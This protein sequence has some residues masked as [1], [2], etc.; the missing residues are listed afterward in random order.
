MTET[1]ASFSRDGRW[2]Y[3]R[4]D[5]PDGRDI[6]RVPSDGGGPP[7]RVTDQGGLL[8]RESADGRTLVY[9]KRDPTSPL[10]GRPVAGGAERQLVDCVQSRSLADGPDGMYYLA[11]A[12]DPTPLYRLDPMTG[13]VR[14]VGEIATG[15][16]AGAY[17][18][19][20]PRDGTVLFSKTTGGADL[21]MIDN[22]R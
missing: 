14:R 1:L 9:T 13:A 22:F 6:W 10:Y 8:A 19:V 5:R 15:A 11:C 12:D 3:Y 16:P 7:E 18:A 17:L 20:S 21:M 2:I 4:Q